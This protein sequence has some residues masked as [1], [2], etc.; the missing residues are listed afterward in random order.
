MSG[1]SVDNDR[2]QIDQVFVMCSLVYLHTSQSES[3][4]MTCLARYMNICT[5]DL[6]SLQLGL[7]VHGE[8]MTRLNSR[9]A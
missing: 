5:V 9:I 7:R 4:C 2:V 3:C 1:R 6:R 8:N